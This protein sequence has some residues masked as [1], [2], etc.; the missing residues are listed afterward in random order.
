MNARF[1]RSANTGV[2][3]CES[4]RERRLWCFPCFPCSCNILTFDWAVNQETGASSRR[5]H[6]DLWTVWIRCRCDAHKKQVYVKQLYPVPETVWVS[7]SQL[8]LEFE[9]QFETVRTSSR[10]RACDP[11]WPQLE[12]PSRMR[13]KCCY[14]QRNL[15][16][17]CCSLFRLQLTS[18]TQPFSQPFRKPF[19]KKVWEVY[20]SKEVC[21]FVIIIDHV[22]AYICVRIVVSRLYNTVTNMSCLPALGVLRCRR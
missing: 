4:I 9:L 21:S 13:K 6:L 16:S 5:Y 22:S 14:S 15:G 12:Q 17:I 2:F 18:H 20:F 11:Q 1:C 8:L 7:W 3:T 19:E 10:Q